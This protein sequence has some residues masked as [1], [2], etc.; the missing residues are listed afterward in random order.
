C[1][2][3]KKLKEIQKYSST[4]ET[5]P[6]RR[7]RFRCQCVPNFRGI[8]NGILSNRLRKLLC[9]LYKNCCPDWPKIDKYQHQGEPKLEFRKK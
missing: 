6:Y 1:I 7:S 5:Y 8:C 3:S 9:A 4:T 2:F